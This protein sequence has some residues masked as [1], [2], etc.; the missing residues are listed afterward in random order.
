M[1]NSEQC[2]TRILDSELCVGKGTD[3]VM[4]VRIL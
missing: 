1:Y 4:L 2:S 3:N